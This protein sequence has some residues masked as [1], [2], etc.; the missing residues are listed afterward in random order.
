MIRDQKL[1]F[2]TYGENKIILQY[3]FKLKITNSFHL[4]KIIV[5]FTIVIYNDNIYHTI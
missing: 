1:T 2:V 4:V 3:D 5:V